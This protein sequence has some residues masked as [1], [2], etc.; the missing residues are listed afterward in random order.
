MDVVGNL[1]THSGLPKHAAESTDSLLAVGR[2][3]W[4]DDEITLRIGHLESVTSDGIKMPTTRDEGHGLSRL[5]EP[6]EVDPINWTA[7]RRR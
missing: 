2:G 4:M 7:D 1:D 3:R 6:S 5:G